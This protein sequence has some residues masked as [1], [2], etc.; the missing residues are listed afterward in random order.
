MASATDQAAS[1][2]PRTSEN[3]SSNTTYSVS[4]ADNED[5]EPPV[6]ARTRSA[7]N[8]TGPEHVE[9][10]SAAEKGSSKV[11]LIFLS[12]QMA[13][14]Q[15]LQCWQVSGLPALGFMA[16]H[17]AFFILLNGQPVATSGFSQNLQAALA[18]FLAI[19]VEICLL[20]GI[21]VAYDQTLWR[22]LRRKALRAY[23]I[24]KLVTLVLSPW[25]LFRPDVTT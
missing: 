18:N 1:L 8:T 24:D 15:L 21:A 17:M 16:T 7:N 10:L 25:N 5:D 11:W 9:M 6:P 20:S 2:S 4:S 23:A 19:A 22:L 14:P 3:L 13:Q 12:E